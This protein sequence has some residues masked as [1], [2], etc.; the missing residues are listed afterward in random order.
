MKRI[1]ATILGVL[2]VVAGAGSVHAESLIGEQFQAIH[3]DI[4]SVGILIDDSADLKKQWAG[5]QAFTGTGPNNTGNIVSVKACDSYGTK[6]CETDKFFNYQALLP[7]CA[8]ESSAN[9]VSSLVATGPDGISHNAIYV[10]DFPG[11]TKYSYVG[12]TAAQLPDSGSN[13]IVSIPDLPHSHGD[14][15]LVAAQLTGNKEGKDPSF[16]ISNFRIGLYAVTFI[17]GR[18]KVPFSATEMSHFEPAVIGNTAADN[19]G[20]DYTNSVIPN[21]A[22]MSETRCALAWPLPLDVSF[23]MTLR[24]KIAIQGWLHGR[25]SDASAS[26]KSEPNGMSSITISGKPVVVPTVFKYFPLAEVPSVITSYY[27]KDAKSLSFDLNFSNAANERSTVR[28]L[29]RYSSEE[30]PEA[31]VW[32]KALSDTAPFSATAWSFRSITGGQLGRSCDIGSGKLNGLVSTNSNMYVSEPPVFNKDDQTL[33]Y[34]VTSPHFLPDGSV[35][36]GTYNLVID[37]D[38]ARCIYG[39]SKAPVSAK[40]SILSS[41]GTEQVAT[42]VLTE[43]NGYIRLAASNFTFS[44]PTIKVKLTQEGAPKEAKRY[45]IYCQNK[46][47]YKREFNGVNPKCPKGYK[48]VAK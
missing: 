22:Q 19:S 12:N 48:K 17:D 36:K 1:F 46:A 10:E 6:G 15:Y 42:T 35:F 44:A 13:F 47:G 23:E 3:P 11:K 9:C 24:M 2:L 31:I 18:Y 16:G 32:Y 38:F 30:F 4:Q 27:K 33:D 40:V 28:T 7:L 5:L 29:N 45:S 14:K 8:T 34:K 41:N 37:S 26:I 20:W 39:F 25:L 21:C 43:K